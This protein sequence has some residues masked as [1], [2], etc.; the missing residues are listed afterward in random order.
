M[1]DWIQKLKSQQKGGNKSFRWFWKSDSDWVEFD[2][3]ISVAAEEVY[4][5]GVVLCVLT[6][7]SGGDKSRKVKVDDQRY[8]DV[9]N[10]VQKRYDDPSK[11]RLVKREEEAVVWYWRHSD[12]MPYPKEIGDKIEKA[13]LSKTPTVQIDEERYIDIGKWKLGVESQENMLQKRYDDNSRSR[14]VKRKGP[15]PVWPVHPTELV[16]NGST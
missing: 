1:P 14:Y 9:Q 7:A 8:I 13:Y 3:S 5:L 6:C 11:M 12:W 2:E 16:R 4:W 15:K 10:M